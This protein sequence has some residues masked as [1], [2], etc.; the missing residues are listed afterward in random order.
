MLNVGECTVSS[1]AQC[2]GPATRPAAPHHAD[3]PHMPPDL[4]IGVY[5]LGPG[6]LPVGLLRGPQE[7]NF[8]LTPAGLDRY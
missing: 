4:L 7:L 8:V 5:T 2:G 1:Q 6:P 3:G